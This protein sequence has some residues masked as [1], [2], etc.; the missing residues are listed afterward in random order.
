VVAIGCLV[1]WLEASD[2][3]KRLN[4]IAAYTTSTALQ[5]WNYG[6]VMQKLSSQL[7]IGTIL[8]QAIPESIGWPGLLV[9][10][11]G[12]VALDRRT[13]LVACALT[14]LFLLPFL[15]FTNLHMVHNY[16]QTANALWLVAALATVI[17]KL[18]D[19]IPRPARIALMLLCLGG[20]V[21][22]SLLFYLPMER[23]DFSRDARMAVAQTLKETVAKDEAVVFVGCDW[24]PEMAFY[25]ER[26]AIYIPQWVSYDDV[27]KIVA[28]PD[29][30]TGGRGVGAVVIWNNS[31]CVA[32]DP[33]WDPRTTEPLVDWAKTVAETRPPLQIADFFVFLGR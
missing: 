28:T 19:V 23:L 16:Y 2:A 11:A 5:S 12:V 29:I 6:T 21:Y 25:A 24:S 4:P 9:L 13:R 8:L 20:Q 31:P 1:P 10:I 17:D 22:Q 30:V 26:R 32:G 7:W 18:F 27:I 33:R 15:L 3:A 14:G